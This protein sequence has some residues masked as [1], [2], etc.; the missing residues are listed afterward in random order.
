VTSEMRVTVT[1]LAMA[2]AMLPIAGCQTPGR[3]KALTNRYYL[4][5]PNALDNTISAY[6]IDA[7]SGALAAVR[8]SPFPTGTGLAGL[9]AEPSG[10]YLYIAD[11]RGNSVSVYRV[12]AGSGA[13]APAGGSPIAAGSDPEDITVKK[14]WRGWKGLSGRGAP[15]P[16]GLLEEETHDSIPFGILKGFEFHVDDPAV[17]RD[18]EDAAGERE[19]SNLGTECQLDGTSFLQLPSRV[20]KARA[21]SPQI[22]K[23]GFLRD[24]RN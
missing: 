6:S 15:P 20:L 11:S 24:R 14:S 8:G 13:L 5:A 23:K 10:K 9:A 19:L 3:G 7:G 16:V 1:V 18:P 21:S 12:D 4:Y 17:S 22:Q 2:A